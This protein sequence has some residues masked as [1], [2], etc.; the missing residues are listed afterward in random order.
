M[1]PSFIN[2][3]DVDINNS[4]FINSVLEKKQSLLKLL[5]KK[6]EYEIHDF[7]SDFQSTDDIIFS[8]GMKCRYYKKK[9]IEKKCY[10]TPYL[11]PII[12]SNTFDIK[13][14]KDVVKNNF[15]NNL[16]FLKGNSNLYRCGFL[17]LPSRS[18]I[19]KTQGSFNPYVFLLNL[20]SSKI[21][22]E[23]NSNKSLTI[24]KNNFCIADYNSKVFKIQN[25]DN[26]LSISFVSLLKTSAHPEPYISTPSINTAHR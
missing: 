25:L 14:L 20:T 2:L 17:F 16:N 1:R 6:K 23:C 19:I 11:V 7:E 26:K 12:S 3:L 13:E 4:N 10:K 18:L 22:I 8:A 15:S 5:N 21:L 24:D 9:L